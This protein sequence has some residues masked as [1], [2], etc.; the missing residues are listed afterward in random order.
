MVR[1]YS[2]PMKWQTVRA[3]CRPPSIQRF[4]EACLQFL[5][6]SKS[7]CGEQVTNT[8]QQ[9]ERPDNQTAGYTIAGL[10]DFSAVGGLS[11]LAMSFAIYF[12]A[13]I[14]QYVQHGEP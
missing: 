3:A 8:L 1:R 10:F 11:G 5:D 9:L 6:W 14:L 2:A 13:G 12:A 7:H 4:T